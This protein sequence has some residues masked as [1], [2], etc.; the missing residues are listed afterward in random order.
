MPL[1]SLDRSDGLET[2]TVP[3]DLASYVADDV[4][5][6]HLPLPSLDR[7]DGLETQTVPRDLASYEIDGDGPAQIR[8][9][10]L[11]RYIQ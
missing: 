6:L 2:Q 8:I 9:T 7:S 10:R 4:R 1:P 5:R 3:R 11:R